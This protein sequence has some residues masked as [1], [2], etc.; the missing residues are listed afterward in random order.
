MVEILYRL[1][2]I[3]NTS[4]T[5]GKRHARKSG[6]EISLSSP[7][8]GVP[9][10]AD[11]KLSASL[12]ESES[13]TAKAELVGVEVNNLGY[14]IDQI[15]SAGKRIIIE[16][17][18]YL[19]EEAKQEFAY[20]LKA[21]WDAGIFFIIVGIWQEQ[22]L[23]TMYNGDLRGRVEEIDVEWTTP[24]LES[25]LEKGA[26]ALNIFLP[27]D[28]TQQMVL[29][30]NK[31]VGL[32]QR[33]AKEF[34]FACR[35]TQTLNSRARLN[36][37]TALDKCRTQICDELSGRFHG[38][39]DAIGHGFRKKD[40]QGPSIYQ[41]IVREAL[42]L[43]SVDQ[44]KG[45]H[46]SKLKSRVLLSDGERCSKAVYPAL[47]KFNELQRKLKIT[48]LIFSYNS[49]SKLFQLIDRDL[50][51][52]KNYKSN[53]WPWESRGPAG[54]TNRVSLPKFIRPTLPSVSELRP[55]VNRLIRTSGVGFARR[56]LVAAYGFTL[57]HAD[58]IIRE[59]AE[60]R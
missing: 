32:L 13:E 41:L 50:L 15:K 33:I 3:A 25:V 51:F 22:N 6:G 42:Q 54:D 31:N 24:E 59:I 55:I 38:F 23:M 48:P 60:G 53:K 46:R 49:Q 17:F 9:V 19:P 4:V 20:T 5:F 27:D 26:D 40:D 35:I 30:A 58:A 52:Y 44:L 34:C 29:D 8:H 2:S 14:V 28:I 11:I 1:N 21:F 43:P 45:I 37:V 39:C 16:D 57:E 36:D 12:E 10:K 18:H 47:K 56:R 7:L